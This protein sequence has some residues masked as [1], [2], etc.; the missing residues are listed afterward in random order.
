MHRETTRDQGTDLRIFP[1]N[2][3]QPRLETTDST[4]SSQDRDE[5]PAEQGKEQTV[6]E[7]S[8]NLPNFT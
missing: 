1:E 7:W 5:G 4:G 6:A 3:Q 2:C 8:L